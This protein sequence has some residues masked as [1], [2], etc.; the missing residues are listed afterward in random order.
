MCV[1]GHWR[2]ALFGEST[3]LVI[4]QGSIKKTIFTASG[5]LCKFYYMDGKSIFPIQEDK[6]GA[7][8]RS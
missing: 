4:Y 6:Y 3:V 7:P 8:K 2:I 5:K 1:K